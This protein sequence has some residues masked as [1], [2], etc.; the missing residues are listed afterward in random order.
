MARLRNRDEFTER[1]LLA[2]ILVLILLAI[3]LHLKA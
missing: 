1:A 3:V 2:L